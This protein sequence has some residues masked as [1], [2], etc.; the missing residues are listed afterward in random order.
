MKV[1][2]RD[3]LKSAI[4]LGIAMQLTNISRDVI[5]DKNNDR[6]YI[7]SNFLILKNTI[8]KADNFTKAH[9]TL[10]KIFH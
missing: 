5:E 6:E 3:S 10:L 7:E 1:K 4:N 9:F 2:N 8:H